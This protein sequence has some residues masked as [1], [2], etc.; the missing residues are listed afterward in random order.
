[1]IRHLYII[2]GCNGAGKTTAAYSLLPH[3]LEVRE[4]VNADEIARG[5]SPFNPEGMAIK[6]GKLMLQR[7]EELLENK[8]SFAIETT[9][10]TKSYVSLVRRAQGA[11]YVVHVL[12][13]YLN[14][15]AL[16]RQRVTERVQHGGHDIPVDVIERRYHAGMRNLFGLFMDRVDRW[17]VYDNSCSNR[18]KIASGGSNVPTIVYDEI[19]FEKMKQQ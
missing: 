17:V 9:L 11:G 13:F 10:A 1:M 15:A 6:A 2:A 7:I 5:L 16:A 3:W 12:F 19:T 14:D 4:F 18:R 8:V